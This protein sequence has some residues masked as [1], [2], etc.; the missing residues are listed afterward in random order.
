MSFDWS[1]YLDLARNLDALAKRESNARLKEA[2]WR[3]ALSRAYY[4][5]YHL[6]SIRV[7]SIPDI[8]RICT[9]S[10]RHTTSGA[11]LENHGC[12]FKFYQQSTNTMASD[13]GTYLQR[14]YTNRVS[15]DYKSSIPGLANK[16]TEQITLAQDIIQG[17]STLA[18]I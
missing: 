3:S 2:Q 13:L 11:C 1:A 16:V 12:V 8:H 9:S 14:L 6:S 10:E 5:A 17:L 18:Q 15:A 7:A 4:A